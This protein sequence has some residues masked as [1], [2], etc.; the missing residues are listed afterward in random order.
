MDVLIM[1]V[2]PPYVEGA[3]IWCNFIAIGRANGTVLALNFRVA[4]VFGTT[5]AAKRTAII[6]AARDARDAYATA[7]NLTLP[8][9]TNIEILGI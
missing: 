8:A 5:L 6:Q 4:F 1:M 9:V 3:T 7:H 2:P